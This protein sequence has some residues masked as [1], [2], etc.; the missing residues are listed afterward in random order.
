[1]TVIT[2]KT[3][4]TSSAAGSDVQSRY[5]IRETTNGKDAIWDAYLENLPH[6]SHV[7]TSLWAQVKGWSGWRVTRVL[8]TDG[9]QVVAGAQMLIRK[10]RFL[11]NIAYIPKGPVF[12]NFDP[13]LGQLLLF[14]LL[15]VASNNDVR[16]LFVQPAHDDAGFT[17]ELVKAGFCQC[18]VETTPSATVIVDLRHDEDA[19]LARMKK[20]MRNGIRRSQRNGIKVREG[21]VDD[22]PM[23][24]RLLVAT[25]GRRGFEPFT[26]RYFQHMWT[27]LNPYGYI[28]LFLAEFENEA[29]SAQLV[30]P[31][32]NTVVAKQIGWSGC[33][34]NL[35]PNEG[36]D[37]GTM[38]WAKSNR[39]DFY[40]LEGIEPEVASV[41][42]KGQPIPTSFADSPTH[43]K[44]R[45]GGDIKVSPGAYCYFSNSMLRLAYNRIGD[46]VIKWPIVKK[47]VGRFRT[48]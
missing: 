41:V 3:T 45:L 43:Y 21:T 24:H 13:R 29:I 36:L 14:R 37:W 30:I 4:K 6:G 12:E 20:G 44:M 26:L 25:S 31:F 15:D 46:T 1:M 48:N 9:G 23:F 11:G 2:H 47:A 7:Q 42:L 32:G 34:G 8:V 27:I 22:L 38:Q 35:K 10:S 19:I 18:P 5:V 39:Y 16:A 40:D 33:H 17:N 28:K